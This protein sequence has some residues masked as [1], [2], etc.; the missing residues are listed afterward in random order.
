MNLRDLS[1]QLNLSQ[2]TVSRALNGYPEVNEATRKRVTEAAARYRY[3]PNVRA[4]TLATGR[5]MVIGHVIPMSKQTELVNMVFSDFVAGAGLVYAQNG[6]TMSLSIVNDDAELQ[7]YQAFAERGA[8][9]GVIVQAPTRDDPRIARLSELKIP[10]VVH[11][12]ASD[13]TSPY[14]WLD[15]NNSRAIKAATE[16]LIDLGHRSIALINGDE[17]MDFAYR[18]R[19]GYC[20]ALRQAGLPEN[21]V[22]MR[23]G[24]MSEP[25]GYQATKQMLALDAPPTAFVASSIVLALGV[26]RAVEEA[27]LR[28]G[29]DV[30]VICFDDDIAY[31]PNAGDTPQFTAVRSSVRAAGAQ[32]A[33]MLI[34]QIKAPMA[35]PKTELWEAELVLGASTGPGPDA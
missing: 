15:V 28:I 16:H 8:V 4:Q 29:Q 12:R 9:D 19:S 35:A 6:Y 27:G 7:A 1:K 5:S 24:D 25:N 18:R 31:L 34:D 23:S 2:T 22:F 17:N 13:V 20:E 21:H 11:G 30:S 14:A 32:C 10:F 26:K 33:T 3:K